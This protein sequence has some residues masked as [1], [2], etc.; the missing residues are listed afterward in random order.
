MR[1]LA[2]ESWVQ[3]Y[4]TLREAGALTAGDLSARCN[5]RYGVRSGDYWGKQLHALADLGYAKRTGRWCNSAPV[6]V[7]LAPDEQQ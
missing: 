5:Q 4:E 2:R 1:V 7:A 3:C 6:W